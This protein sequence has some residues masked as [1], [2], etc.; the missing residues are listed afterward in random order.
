M[1]EKDLE[2]I[3]A[4]VSREFKQAERVSEIAKD[5]ERRSAEYSK[6][7]A[8]VTTA[9]DLSKQFMFAVFKKVLCQSPD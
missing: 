2:K 3:F 5:Y 4:E 7:L 8:A 1:T 6:D 9:F